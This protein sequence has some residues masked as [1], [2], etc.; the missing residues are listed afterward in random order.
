MRISDHIRRS[1]NGPPGPLAMDIT[2][3]VH[4]QD[5]VCV[6]MHISSLLALSRSISSEGPVS[7]LVVKKRQG[8]HAHSFYLDLV[9]ASSVPD[10]YYLLVHLPPLQK[11]PHPARLRFVSGPLRSGL[12]CP[13]YSCSFFGS[14]AH[15]QQRRGVQACVARQGP[16]LGVYRKLGFPPPYPI[17]PS[18]RCT[19]MQW[20]NCTANN[21]PTWLSILLPRSSSAYLSTTLAFAHAD[22]PATSHQSRNISRQEAG[23]PG[24]IFHVFP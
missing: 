6:R 7:A 14:A 23:A 19:I 1:S 17:Y 8:T 4:M 20:L 15:R 5:P 9:L 24:M 11:L 2:S 16:S 22:T 13:Q 21:P 12:L 18:S 10:R 3:T